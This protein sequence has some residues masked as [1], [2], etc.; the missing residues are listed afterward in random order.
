MRTLRKKQPIQ[1]TQITKN[2]NHKG[3]N[4]VQ[5]S[6]P[7]SSPQ[8]DQSNGLAFPILFQESPPTPSPGWSPGTWR[9]QRGT[10]ETMGL[11]SEF[12]ERRS[13]TPPCLILTT[14]QLGLVP[15]SISH[16][17]ERFSFHQ[18][19]WLNL[20]RNTSQNG[21]GHITST[22]NIQKLMFLWSQHQLHLQ[23]KTKE[24]NIL[25][26][27]LQWW[28]TQ[29]MKEV[30]APKMFIL[31]LK[32]QFIWEIMRFELQ[33]SILSQTHLWKY[34]TPILRVTGIGNQ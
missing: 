9:R 8:E 5:K 30:G 23:D 4:L 26:K 12:P 1:A 20:T 22:K 18:K 17:G 25:T 29:H 15:C 16:T 33:T 27:E 2:S 7:T 3:V 10:W 21:V 28:D 11:A 24:Q 31:T 13:M 34:F 32:F 14:G 19:V 6:M